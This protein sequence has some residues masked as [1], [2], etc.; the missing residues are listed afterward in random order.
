VD[1]ERIPE[2]NARAVKHASASPKPL[3]YWQN[4]LVNAVYR[5]RRRRLSAFEEAVENLENVKE[6]YDATVEFMKRLYQDAHVVHADLSEYN[7]L[8]D[9]QAD[10]GNS[11]IWGSLCL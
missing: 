10:P 6:V 3:K 2:P 5:A 1:K 8:V 4:V 11:L 7:I 9:D